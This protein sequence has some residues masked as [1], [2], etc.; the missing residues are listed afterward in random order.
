MAR[1][2]DTSPIGDALVW[3]SRIIAIGLFMFLPGV[4]GGWFDARLGTGF[5]GPAG[6][7]LGFSAALAWLVQISGGRRRGERRS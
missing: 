2:P 7:L 6:F 3:S 4:A 5:L 1:P